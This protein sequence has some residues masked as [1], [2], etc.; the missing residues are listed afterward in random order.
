MRSFTEVRQTD[1]QDRRMTQNVLH[2]PLG[3]LHYFHFT[4]LKLQLHGFSLPFSTSACVFKSQA[5][6]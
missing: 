6:F 5:D 3:V 4:Y 1:Q 2:T